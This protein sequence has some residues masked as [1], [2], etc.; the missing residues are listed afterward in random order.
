MASTSWMLQEVQERHW[1]QIYCLKYTGKIAIAVA[2]SGI[3][4][5]LLTGGRTA[6]LTFKLPL[7]LNTNESPTYNIVKSSGGAQVLRK[8]S[9]IIW[10]EC[11]MSHNG[12]G[13]YFISLHFIF[14]IYY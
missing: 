2:S 5:T 9:L 4:A 3:S 10:D 8:C 12:N 6:D 1:S 11:T 14:S 7:D 13:L